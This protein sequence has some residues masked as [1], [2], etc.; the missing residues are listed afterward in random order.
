MN[1]FCTPTV[2]ATPKR[3]AVPCGG[4]MVRMR[5]RKALKKVGPELLR[6]GRI[7]TPSDRRVQNSRPVRN[8][9]A[10]K[11]RDQNSLQKV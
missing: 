6:K 11:G 3:W 4:E 10:S 1:L 8:I 7:G 5:D 9:A 2:R